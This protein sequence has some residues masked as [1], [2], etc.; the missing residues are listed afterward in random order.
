M[1]SHILYGLKKFGITIGYSILGVFRF[2]FRPISA[3]GTFVINSESNEDSW[4]DFNEH[5]RKSLEEI[6]VEECLDNGNTEQ[7]CRSR[8]SIAA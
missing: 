7:V 5:Y 2:F 4:T 1:A 6:D 8:V 3:W